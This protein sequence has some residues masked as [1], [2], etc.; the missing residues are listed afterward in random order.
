MRDTMYDRKS[1]ISKR[2]ENPHDSKKRYFLLLESDATL[3]G[4]RGAMKYTRN[5]S[6]IYN[7]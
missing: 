2:L 6:E 5:I 3:S 7:V 1:T 4:K